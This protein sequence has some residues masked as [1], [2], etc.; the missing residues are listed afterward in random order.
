VHECIEDKQVELSFIMG[1]ENPADM[2]TKN[3]GAIK[4]YKFREQLGLE[5]KIKW[6]GNDGECF[7]RLEST[8]K[9]LEWSKLTKSG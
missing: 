2:F 8:V 7:I 3:L 9:Q 6:I 4:F 5:Y 1:S